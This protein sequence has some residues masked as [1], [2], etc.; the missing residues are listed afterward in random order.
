MK[1]RFR[2]AGPSA[3]VSSIHGSP[4][5]VVLCGYGVVAAPRD[6]GYDG[7]PTPES[8]ERG[9]A[10]GNAWSTMGAAGDCQCLDHRSGEG[11][12][13]RAAVV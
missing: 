4:S 10:A 5:N 7:W 3:R 13:G 1:R 11:E 8:D 6:I 2:T 12:L 9:A